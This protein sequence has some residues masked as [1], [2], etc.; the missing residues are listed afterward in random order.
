MADAILGSPELLCG[1]IHVKSCDAKTLLPSPLT[2]TANFIWLFG[3]H[4]SHLTDIGPDLSIWQLFPSPGYV[5][6]TSYNIKSTPISFDLL[7]WTHMVYD[8]Q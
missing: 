8:G 2:S 5:V 6:P 3:N 7:V 1:S 4:F